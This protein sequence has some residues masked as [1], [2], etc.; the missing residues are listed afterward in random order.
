MIESDEPIPPYTF[1]KHGD[2][3]AIYEGR[4]PNMHGYK[5]AFVTEVD[6]TRIEV[7]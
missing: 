6:F 2:G 1:E 3:Y 5:V 4:T 7:M